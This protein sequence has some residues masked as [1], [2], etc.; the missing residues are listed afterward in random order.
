MHHVR[1]LAVLALALLVAGCGV[2][3]APSPTPREMDDVIAALVLRGV[4][5]AHL[6]SGDAGCPGSQLYRNGVHF[7]VSLSGDPATYDVYLLRWGT[8]A[9]YAATEAAFG[10]CVADFS[11]AHTAA[12]VSQIELTPW[13]VYGP[14]WPDSLRSTLDAALHSVGGG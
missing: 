9:E 5:V 10:A 8:P 7:Q 12:S 11:A 2:F 13:R 4:T 14:G 6:T 1:L 3:V